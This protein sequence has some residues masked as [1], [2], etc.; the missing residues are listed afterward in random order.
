VLYAREIRTTFE[1]FEGRC[2]HCQQ[3]IIFNRLENLDD[4]VQIDFAEVTCLNEA[5][6]QPFAINGDTVDPPFAQMLFSAFPLMD[7]KQ[8]GD[9]TVAICRSYEMFF[10]HSLYEMLVWQPFVGERYEP[11]PVKTAERPEAARA[12]ALFDGSRDIIWT[13]ADELRVRYAA[14]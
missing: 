3:W 7:R 1:T 2:P 11:D 8:Y 14:I 13:L 9:A 10:A 12:K 5:C 4:A 6:R